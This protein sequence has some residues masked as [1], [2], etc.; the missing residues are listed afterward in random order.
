MKINIPFSPDMAEAVITGRKTCTTRTK[1]YGKPGDTFIVKS[2]EMELVDVS[3]VTVG[4]VAFCLHQEEGFH[5][6]EG[7]INKWKE[8]YPRK[9]YVQSPLVWLHIFE[10]KLIK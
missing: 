6:V 2:K 10:E 4:Y 7:F 8:L 5:S 9:G 1:R 3:Q